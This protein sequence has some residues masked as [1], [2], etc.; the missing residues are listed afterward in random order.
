MFVEFLAP[1]PKAGIQEHVA[2]E[3]GASLIV[4]GFAKEVEAPPAPEFQVR[5]KEAFF[6]L[7]VTKFSEYRTAVLRA[8]CPKCG[9][10]DTY[11]GS[12]AKENI[13]RNFLR[14]LCVHFRDVKM[15]DEMIAAYSAAHR[16]EIIPT[17]AGGF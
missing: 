15:T 2:R 9:R 4:A 12:P 16:P 11:P 1:S 17:S 3:V 14:F 6:E 10:H 13:E 8:N 5:Q 7:V